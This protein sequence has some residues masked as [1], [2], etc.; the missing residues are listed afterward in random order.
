MSSDLRLVDLDRARRA[1]WPGFSQ[2]FVSAKKLLPK[3]T[4][5]R[6]AGQPRRLRLERY[7]L[8]DES[9][10]AIVKM[11]TVQ[12]CPTRLRDDAQR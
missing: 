1:L 11:A 4:D 8:Q 9:S 12:Q 5:L 10:F 6:F 3:R 7:V 2:R